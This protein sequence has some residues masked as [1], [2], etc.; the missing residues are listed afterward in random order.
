MA[1]IRI[2]NVDSCQQKHHGHGL[3]QMHYNATPALGKA[4]TAR[5]AQTPAGRAAGKAAHARYAQ[6]PARKA[7]QARYYAAAKERAKGLSGTPQALGSRSVPDLPQ[8]DL[9]TRQRVRSQ[10]RSRTR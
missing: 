8:P 3:C 2:C 1:T 5:Y 7:S 10:G 6:T 4:A 9:E